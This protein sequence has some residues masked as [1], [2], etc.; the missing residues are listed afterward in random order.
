MWHKY[1]IDYY[2]AIKKN[3]ITLFAGKIHETLK[4]YVKQYKLGSEGK[5][6]LF[7]VLCGD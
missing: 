3:E 2:L 6:P 7:S 4:H 5:I 1:T